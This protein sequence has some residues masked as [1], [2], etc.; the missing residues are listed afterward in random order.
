LSQAVFRPAS[1]NDCAHLALFADM[2]TRR[3]TSHLW[4]HPAQ[5]GQSVFEAGR[6]MI[7]NDDRHYTHFTN[8]RVLELAGQI[9]GA[10]NGYVIPEPSAAAAPLPA[11][12]RELNELKAMAAGTWYIS[13][14]ALYPEYQGQGLGKSLLDEAATLALAAGHDR[15]TLMVGS[16]NS[17]AHRLYLRCGFQE[18]ARRPFTAFP[19]SDMPGEWILMEKVLA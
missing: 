14:A 6:A 8:W 5:P 1:E 15:L 9:A 17:T 2:A 18:Q 16:F 10:F 12:V 3:L 7:R 19:G 4:G 13:A 11:A